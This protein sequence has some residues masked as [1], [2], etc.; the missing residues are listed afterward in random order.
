[1][2]HFLEN[3][4]FS[5]VWLHSGNCLDMFGSLET[6]VDGRRWGASQQRFPENDFRQ[7]LAEVIFHQNALIFLDQRKSFSID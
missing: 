3:I 7:I 4:F 2:S 6:K 1:M 5:S